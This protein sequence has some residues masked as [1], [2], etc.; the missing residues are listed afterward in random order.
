MWTLLA[1]WPAPF[2]LLAIISALLQ[3]PSREEFAIVAIVVINFSLVY[4]AVLAITRFFVGE[5]SP[6]SVGIAVAVALAYHIVAALLPR[7][8]SGL[9]R[10]GAGDLMLLG[11]GVIYE[12]IGRLTL[13]S[14]RGALHEPQ[15][16]ADAMTHPGGDTYFVH[17]ALAVDGGWLLRGELSAESGL[18]MR[19][20]TRVKTPFAIETVP[21]PDE[22][23]P[24]AEQLEAGA[25][26][27]L[28]PDLL[29]VVVPGAEAQIVR[30]PAQTQT[31]IRDA[32]RMESEFRDGFWS[33]LGA[34]SDRISA[35]RIGPDGQL[36]DRVESPATQ[37]DPVAITT[38]GATMYFVTRSYG[39]SELLSGHVATG[40]VLDSPA[41]AEFTAYLRSVELSGSI[42]LFG[43]ETAL[44]IVGYD[45]AQKT[46]VALRYPSSTSFA[47]T[48]GMF[49]HA[50]VDGDVLVT[51]TGRGVTRFDADGAKVVSDAWVWRGT[52]SVAHGVLMGGVKDRQSRM[53]TLSSFEAASPTP[54]L[55]ELHLEVR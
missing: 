41:S 3:W 38:V 20:V 45:A 34:Q 12:E 39:D 35:A 52:L 44:W 30:L 53:I 13:G 8:D 24:I 46:S 5:F 32:I 36:V 9:I 22:V 37:E 26:H 14:R 31:W 28:A 4:A 25:Y 18:A 54:F 27:A 11:G 23:K 55:P 7:P 43:G 48:P 29:Y 17:Q 6:K 10:I 51:S 15:R 50:I 21:V 19:H 2:F 1:A 49:S 47:I 16:V 42:A 33:V 40:G